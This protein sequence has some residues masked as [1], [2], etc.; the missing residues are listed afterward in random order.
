MV[1]VCVITTSTLLS[2]FG[3]LP[4]KTGRGFFVDGKPRFFIDRVPTSKE[5]IMRHHKLCL[6]LVDLYRSYTCRDN[7]HKKHHGDFRIWDK[8]QEAEVIFAEKNEEDGDVKFCFDEIPWPNPRGWGG[9]CGWN[10]LSEMDD[11]LRW[12]KSLEVV[13]VIT[14]VHRGKTVPVKK[15]RICACGETKE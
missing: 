4:L 5:I 8:E 11:P 2:G 1:G 15:Q 6:K 12:L 13:Q 3:F 10:W 14:V 9:P 7:G